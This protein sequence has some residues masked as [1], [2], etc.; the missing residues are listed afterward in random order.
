MAVVGFSGRRQ[1]NRPMKVPLIFAAAGCIIVAVL[2]VLFP[3]ADTVQW[4]ARHL[5]H[6][7]DP[8]RAVP[9]NWPSH[10]GVAFAVAGGILFLVSWLKP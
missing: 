1:T 4:L 8:S 10:A 2:L 6:P 5:S 9:L 7:L 3:D